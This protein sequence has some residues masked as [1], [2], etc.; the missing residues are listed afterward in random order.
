MGIAG[1]PRYGGSA[2][3]FGDVDQP[4]QAKYYNGLPWAVTR[5]QHDKRN[6]PRRLA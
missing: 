1:A 2:Y 4:V 3:S 6:G 5:S